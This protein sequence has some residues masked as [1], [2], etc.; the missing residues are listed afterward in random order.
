[1]CVSDEE[2]GS[3]SCVPLCMMWFFAV[4]RQEIWLLVSDW[5]ATPGIENVPTFVQLMVRGFQA[6]GVRVWVF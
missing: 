6:I 5:L 2:M 3:C 1:M 4:T